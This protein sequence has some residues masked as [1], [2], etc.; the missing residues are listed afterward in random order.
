MRLGEIHPELHGYEPREFLP[1]QSGTAVSLRHTVGLAD[2]ID[3]L[4]GGTA[5]DDGLP[6]TLMENIAA[7]GLKHFKVKFTGPH[8]LPRLD[9]VFET[10]AIRAG[11]GVRFTLD[12][13][14][15]FRSV[16]EFAATW[17]A[18]EALP[19][20]RGVRAGLICVEQ[21]I[22][23]AIALAEGPLA[24]LL[25]W[26]ERPPLI[27]DESDAEFDSVRRAL[28]GGY[29]GTSHKNC[30]GVFRG[31][32]NACLLARRRRNGDGRL[33]Q[34]GEDLANVGPVALLQDLAV[35]AALGIESVE[36]NGHHYFRGLSFL[37]ETVQRQ[38]VD[39]HSDLYRWHP[40]GFAALAPS[41]G[42][43]R[44]GSVT[45]A[46]FG[47]AFIPDLSRPPG[48]QRPLSRLVLP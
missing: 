6:E 3:A 36:R 46:P 7:Y 41:G 9:R 42:R 5:I 32:A 39:F 26:T 37:P 17:T 23:R 25:R 45:S 27:I 34:T 20:W 40:R 18:I 11:E 47:L 33:L 15:S 13:N 2:P 28:D 43:I 31:V 24:E 14:E 38:V 44:I 12:G 29:L 19:A 21:P 4:D 8:D 10:I 30:K 22:H 1:A 16:A 35:Q 48:H